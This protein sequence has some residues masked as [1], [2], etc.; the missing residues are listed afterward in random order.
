MLVSEV[1]EDDGFEVIEAATAP[2]ALAL[3]EKRAGNVE[4]LFTDIDMP[5]GMD[6]L[7]LAYLVS[8]RWPHVAIVVTSGVARLGVDQLPGDGVFIAK[9]YASKTPGRVIRELIHQHTRRLH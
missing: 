6:G 7:E 8:A 5:G 9:P 2:A 3:L 4:A 1:L